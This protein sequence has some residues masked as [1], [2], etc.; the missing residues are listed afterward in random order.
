[1]LIQ[2]AEVFTPDEAAA[3][4]QRLDAADWVDGKV[5]AGFQSASVKHN[6]QLSEQHPLA[7]EL[8]KDGAG[9]DPARARLRCQFRRRLPDAQTA[10]PY[11][12][13]D[14]VQ[15]RIPCFCDGLRHPGPP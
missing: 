3:I 7:Q 6:R 4:R 8:G 15:S 13:I 1:M 9:R 12:T 2:I 14:V 5:T 10:V 11:Q